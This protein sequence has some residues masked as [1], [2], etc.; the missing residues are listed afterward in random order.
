MSASTG[1]ILITTLFIYGDDAARILAYYPTPLISHQAVFR[2]L[3]LELHKR[4]HELVVIT[5]DPM[6]SRE[7]APA[8]LTEINLHD[9]SYNAWKTEASMPAAATQGSKE[10][11]QKQYAPIYKLL[12]KLVGMQLSTPEVQALIKDK[13]KTFDL[14][15][16]EAYIDS[17]LGLS[18][19]FKAPVIQ[20]SSVGAAVNNLEVIGAPMHPLLFPT[21]VHS[22]IYNLTLWEKL[23][24]IKT[25]IDHVSV[26]K[27]TNIYAEEMLKNV[28]GPDVPPMDELWKNVDMLFLNVFPMWDFN[29]PLPPNVILLGGIHQKP[30]KDLPKDL[31]EFL[32]ASKNGV[33]YVSF[34]TNADAALLPPH[35]LEVMVNVFS[36]LPYDILWKWNNDELPGRTKNIRI[37]KW[38]PQ[39]DLLKHHKVKLFITQGG[40]QS[41]DEAID[42]G[43]PLIGIPLLGDQWF[44]VEQYLFHKIGLYV[45]IETITEE[46]FGNAI[47][48]ILHNDSYRRNIR[49]LKTLIQD[50]PQTPLE[51]AVWWT[52]YVIRNG[53]ARHLRSPT[54]TITWAE[55]LELELVFYILLT[56]ISV[57]IAIL[58]ICCKI[59]RLLTRNSKKVKKS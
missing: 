14:I 55:Y 5:T 49:R 41:T 17:A 29:R 8:N 43:V 51:R 16:L 26:M 58:F 23:T 24:Q 1:L 37:S 39:A 32:D 2:H 4:G 9:M 7:E 25:F 36:K 21:L 27:Q 22:R 15:L 50:Q 18:H 30:E 47:E 44:N 19:V 46:K 57:S 56:I 54:A 11:F 42:A 48:E 12:V 38:L 40:M 35:K 31:N 34:G 59:Y 6:F 3:T 53:G 28:I 33:I 52:E 45:D 13:T 20:F 10:S